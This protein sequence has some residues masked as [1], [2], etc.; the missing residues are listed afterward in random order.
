[1]SLCYNP[2][3]NSIIVNIIKARNL[4]AMDIGGTSGAGGFSRQRA[5]EAPATLESC[6]MWTAG[7]TPCLSAPTLRP[8][9]RSRPLCPR[10]SGGPLWSSLWASITF[11]SAHPRI[12]K[13]GTLW[14]GDPA[15]SPSSACD[16]G[17]DLASWG[18]V[19]LVFPGGHQ[20]MAKVPP[21]AP[22]IR[23]SPR[24]PSFLLGAFL[25][26]PWKES[27]PPL[28]PPASTPEGRR[29]ARGA[30]HCPADPSPPRSQTPT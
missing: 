20:V 6:R 2:S 28:P 4:K 5:G 10:A 26:P 24:F 15:Y 23:R 21:G 29:G 30:P 1:M 25:I 8:R 18:S 16:L 14:G 11:D 22:S 9:R 7:S 27:T 3:A 19:S 17:Q 13:K 12:R